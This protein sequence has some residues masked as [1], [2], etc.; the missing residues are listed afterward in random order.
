MM[1]KKIGIV[2]MLSLSV[3]GGVARVCFDLIKELNNLG[4]KIYVLTPFKLDYNK[5][6]ELYGNIHIYRVY[7]P[8]WIKAKFCKDAILSRKLMKKQ[9]IKMAKEVDMIID[10]DG[11]VL[12][13]YLPE[14][15]DK[16]KY[17]VWRLCCTKPQE[18]S[19]GEKNIKKSIKNSFH[20]F[21]LDNKKNQPSKD[22]KIYALDKWTKKELVDYWGMDENMEYLYPPIQVNELL[23]KG[24]KKKNQITVLGRISHEKRIDDSIKIFFNGT[25]NFPDYKLIILGGLIS[26]SADYMKDLK[27][28]IEELGNPERVEIIESPS[29]NKI[30]EVL[31]NSKVLIDSQRDVSLTM[32]A[33]ESM[34]AGCVVL[35]YKNAGTYL[36]V[37]EN[38]KFGFGFNNTEEGS[39]KLEKILENY[40]KINIKKII[41]RTKAFSREK[42][43]ENIRRILN[44]TI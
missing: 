24:N 30:R 1:N 20:R 17:M 40:S 31:L 42:F 19:W 27:N 15:F 41:E 23:Y 36:D 5:I 21:F 34:A 12:Q 32:T 6:K 9:F 35:A 44:E 18:S 7:Y 29:F 25:K 22:F 13:D 14:S 8:G 26:D 3:G 11:G 10:I 39:E 16:S 38:G 37:L 4:N 2:V 28:L 33:I 43:I